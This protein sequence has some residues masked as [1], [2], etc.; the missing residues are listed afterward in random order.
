M[1]SSPV[2]S[3]T[4]VRRLA[5]WINSFMGGSWLTGGST[6]P[7]APLGS[8]LTLLRTSVRPVAGSSWPGFD[9]GHE[10]PRRLLWLDAAVFFIAVQPPSTL[11]AESA[12][13]K[14]SAKAKTP[15]AAT[16][17][18]LLFRSLSP[19]LIVEGTGAEQR[20][21]A[22]AKE[23]TVSLPNAAVTATEFGPA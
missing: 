23:A 22:A 5:L 14:S 1:S 11:K 16:L 4:C 7:V 3:C 2:S 21:A 17:E 15:Q 13:T 10:E 6:V 12:H 19:V 8:W 9:G 20:E 18:A